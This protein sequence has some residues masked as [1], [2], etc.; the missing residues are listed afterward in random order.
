MFTIDLIFYGYIQQEVALKNRV[1]I[2]LRYTNKLDG[3]MNYHGL[4]HSLTWRAL[5]RTEYCGTFFK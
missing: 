2:T 1:I 5:F 4:D 3:I